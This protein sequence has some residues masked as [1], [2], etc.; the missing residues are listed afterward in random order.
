TTATGF[1][2]FE[3]SSIKSGR[4]LY[5]EGFGRRFGWDR[6]TFPLSAPSHGIS[7]SPDERQLWVLDTPN[8]DVH[9]FDVQGVPRRPPRRIADVKL[10]HTFAGRQAS[11]SQDCERD[12]WLAHSQSGCLVFVGDTGDV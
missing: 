12:G 5:S 3:V 10:S 9:V 11:C 1:L 6:A 7:L 8:A 2:G 4:L